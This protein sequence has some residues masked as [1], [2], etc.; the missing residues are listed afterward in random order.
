M[1]GNPVFY[2]KSAA[3]S[4]TDAAK[5]LDDLHLDGL[6]KHAREIR[7]EINPNIIQPIMAHRGQLRA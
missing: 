2:L 6:A 7:D 1:I 4:L 5:A 3:E